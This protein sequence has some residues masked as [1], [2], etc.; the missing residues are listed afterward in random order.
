MAKITDFGTSRTLTHESEVKEHRLVL[1]REHM[2]EPYAQIG[3]EDEDLQKG[4]D[5]DEDE[6]ED[7]DLKPTAAWRLRRQYS[8]GR[9]SHEYC[10][11]EG[12]R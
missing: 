2:E 11:P 6:D 4:K 1:L 9:T 12:F 3:A 10:P 5:E 7:E 8:K